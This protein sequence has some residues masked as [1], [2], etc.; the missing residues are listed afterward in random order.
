MGVGGQPPPRTAAP[1]RVPILHPG[2]HHAGLAC[3][4]EALHRQLSQAPGHHGHRAEVAAGAQAGAAGCR[5]AQPLLGAPALEA[6]LRAHEGH[7]H[8]SG[9]QLLATSPLLPGSEVTCPWK[10]C[11][12][13][14]KTLSQKVKKPPGVASGVQISDVEKACALSGGRG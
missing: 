12:A 4:Q 1:R 9:A 8:V 2:L 6:V 10:P 14:D 7:L 3:A 5:P 11:S 13:W